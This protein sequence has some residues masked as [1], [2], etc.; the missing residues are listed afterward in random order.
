M[1]LAKEL[2]VPL[3]TKLFLHFLTSS[4]LDK[5]AES[6]L[7]LSLKVKMNDSHVSLLHARITGVC[8]ARCLLLF[9][10]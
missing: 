3:I 10:E 9:K 5:F 8:L 2:Q 6:S 1:S 4:I 7:L